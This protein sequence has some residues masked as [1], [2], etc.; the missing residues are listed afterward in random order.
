MLEMTRMMKFC[1]EEYFHMTI[2][3][4]CLGLSTFN[5]PKKPQKHSRS[6]H[7]STA[8][9]AGRGKTRHAHVDPGVD[10]PGPPWKGLPYDK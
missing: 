7:A 3:M 5:P 2:S 9:F 10:Q 6:L 8:D 1:N 4:H